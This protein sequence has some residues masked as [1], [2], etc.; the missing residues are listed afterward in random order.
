MENGILKI[1][2]LTRE[3]VVITRILKAIRQIFSLIVHG[4]A[5]RNK[6]CGMELQTE[7]SAAVLTV[8]TFL[9]ECT[10][11]ILSLLTKRRI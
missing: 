8:K 7:I 10:L 2:A 1:I 11:L 6:R 5:D 9:P 3:I 4:V